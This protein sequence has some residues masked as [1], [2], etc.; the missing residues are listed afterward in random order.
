[1]WILIMSYLHDARQ[2]VGGVARKSRMGR[3][4]RSGR[5]GGPSPPPGA[6]SEPG[7]ANVSRVSPF[8]GEILA[9]PRRDHLDR[10]RGGEREWER[11]SELER[12]DKSAE[13]YLPFCRGELAHCSSGADVW[14]PF[15]WRSKRQKNKT[16][17]SSFCHDDAFF[18]IHWNAPP[19]F[20]SQLQTSS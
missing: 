11:A 8:R 20:Q 13:S 17:Q 5:D 14:Q 4:E 6:S 9:S 19:K 18:C 1:M 2:E 10:A 12:S 15:H 16:K 7:G 3:G